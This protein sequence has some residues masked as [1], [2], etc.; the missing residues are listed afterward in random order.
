M[1][2]LIKKNGQWCPYKPTSFCRSYGVMQFDVQT[3]SV[4]FDSKC[5]NCLWG[6]RNHSIDVALSISDSS[7]RIEV[8][9]FVYV[10]VSGSSPGDLKRIMLQCL[11]KTVLLFCLARFIYVS[12]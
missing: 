4:K 2:F 3:Y 12:D 1:S 7:L 5:L 10:Q 6:S 8:V 9:M 11:R